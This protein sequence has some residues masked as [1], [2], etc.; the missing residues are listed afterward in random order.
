MPEMQKLSNA[1]QL[2]TMLILSWFLVPV[3]GLV[4]ACVPFF[5]SLPPESP[6]NNLG[7]RIGLVVVSLVIGLSIGWY[8]KRTYPKEIW[9]GDEIELHYINKT[10]KRPYSDVDTAQ[11]QNRQGSFS[12][13]S[14]VGLNVEETILK[15][16]FKGG[17]AVDISV[18]PDQRTPFIDEL[19]RRLQVESSEPEEV[20][21]V[22]L[23]RL[24]YNA[25]YFVVTHCVFHDFERF[26]SICRQHPEM[27]SPYLLA[28]AC[29]VTQI[30]PP[31]SPI[32]FVDCHFGNLAQQEYLAL[33]YQ[34]P[35]AIDF[36]DED[37]MQRLMAGN[38]MVLAPYFSV[39][40]FDSQ[41]EPRYFVLGQA[42]LG[43]GT[44]VR[45]VTS[46]GTNSNRGPG[47]SPKLELFLA[48]IANS[49]KPR[50]A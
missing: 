16:R 13:G 42:P 12:G 10:I 43:G 7:V 28:M 22:P 19:Q 41:S 50:N 33:E 27:V 9:L 37:P 23:E 30:K 47:P 15:L 3:L 44:T 6:V 29:Q 20:Q 48:A 2:R 46:A 45:E 21:P 35:R 39:V 5:V 31:A 4:P 1:R 8:V 32:K 17:P 26:I 18:P 38:D 14:S 34:T 36:D 40:L 49:I 11:L 24:A 25:A